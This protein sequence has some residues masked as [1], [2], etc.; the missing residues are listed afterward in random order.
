MG[1]L[2]TDEDFIEAWIDRWCGLGDLLFDVISTDKPIGTSQ[3]PGEIEEKIY[4][5]LR[6]WFSE[7][8]GHF[9]LLWKN[10]YQSV[11]WNLEIDQ[12]IIREI[13]D[14]EMCLENPFRTFY[15]LESLEVLLH[16]AAG[17]GES[18]PTKEQAWE[19]LMTF[20]RV[21]SLALSFVTT[22]KW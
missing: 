14:A 16:C 13:K 22:E 9:L 3:Q 17:S 1:Y 2:V 4:Q 8:E 18:Y 21:S 20:L 7:N 11:D 19:T 10:Y 12:D 5:D 15:M 6:S